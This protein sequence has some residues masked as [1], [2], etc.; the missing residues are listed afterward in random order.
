MQESYLTIF[1]DIVR[2]GGWCGR[3]LSAAG[4]NAGGL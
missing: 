2:S 3:V 1:L 4:T